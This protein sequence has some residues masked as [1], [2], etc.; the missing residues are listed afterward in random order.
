MFS[1]PLNEASRAKRCPRAQGDPMGSITASPADIALA[2]SD[3]T[4]FKTVC[5]G[6][7]PISR[8]QLA[9]VRAGLDKK[10]RAFVGRNRAEIVEIAAKG[11]TKKGEM[12]PAVVEFLASVDAMYAKGSR[13]KSAH[14]VLALCPPA[15]KRAKKA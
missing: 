10:A 5:A 11:K 6:Y 3:P 12:K 8:T 13:V 4:G 1:A 2:A 9:H 14:I 15:K 7:A